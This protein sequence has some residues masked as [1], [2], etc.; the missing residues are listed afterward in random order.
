VLE[1]GQ[2]QI[3]IDSLGIGEYNSGEIKIIV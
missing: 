3:K 1:N 2:I